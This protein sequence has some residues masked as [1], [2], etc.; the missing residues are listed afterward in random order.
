MVGGAFGEADVMA[1]AKN[2]SVA[3]LSESG[4]LDAKSGKVRLLKRDEY[5]QDWQPGA[6]DAR[7]PVWECTQQLVRALQEQGEGA[8]ARLCHALGGKAEPARDLAYRLYSICERKGWA[9]EALA[10]N[11]LVIAWPE[12]TRLASNP[13]IAMPHTGLFA[14]GEV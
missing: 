12:I 6:P 4:V 14:G 13:N 3:G 8:A 5:P 1:R 11:S 10:Y 2:T 9:Q 7:V